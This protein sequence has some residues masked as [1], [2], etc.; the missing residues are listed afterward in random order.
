MA[1][2][3]P[4][5]QAPILLVH[6][7]IGYDRIK[8]GNFTLASYFRGIPELLDGAGNRVMMTRVSPTAGVA[9]RAGQ[10]KAYLDRQAPGEPVHILA[11]SMGGLDA[12]YLVSRL[13][14]AGR[15]LSLT[16]IGTPHRGSALADWGM[17]RFER[18]FRPCFNLL[19]LPSQAFDD[20]TTV[21]C[22]E[23]NAEVPDVPGV[24][25]FSVAGR[26]EPDFLRPGWRLPQQII[27]EAEGPNDGLVSLASASYGESCEVWD[28]DHLS[29]I[30]WP[31]LRARLCGR[32]RERTPDYGR[33]I[34]RLADEGF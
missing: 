29:L 24:R 4:K 20:L 31:N 34:S 19:R 6:G 28:G 23:F 1:T 17:K 9:V 16:T 21:R 3:V 7:L 5:L 11:H 32:W 22:R 15:V 25:Y 18:L 30:N 14:D 27:E 33:L 2:A 12:R 8:I 26:H 13:L 10:L